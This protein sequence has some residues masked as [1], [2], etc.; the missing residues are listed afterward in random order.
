MLVGDD[1]VNIESYSTNIQKLYEQVKQDKALH[2]KHA[3]LHAKAF[4]KEAKKTEDASL[5]GVAYFYLGS[6]CFDF[7]HNNKDFQT[8]LQQAILYLQNT[9]ETGYLMQ[10]YNHLG[11]D[12]HNHGNIQLSMDYY[13]KA[14]N[15]LGSQDPTEITAMIMFNI[16]QIYIQIEEYKIALRYIKEAHR[17]IHKLPTTERAMLEGYCYCSEGNINLLLHR[18][19][20]ARRSLA[21]LDKV[22]SESAAPE[23]ISQDLFFMLFRIRM[24]NEEGDEAARDR[25]I[26]LFLQQLKRGEMDLGSI[27]EVLD[28]IQLMIEIEHYNAA[29]ETVCY[30]API[31]AESDIPNIQESFAKHRITLYSQMNDEAAYLG[32]LNDYYRYAELHK[33]SA[34][35]AY[36]IALET[37]LSLDAMKKENERLSAAANTDRLT[38]IPNRGALNDYLEEVFE[39]CYHMEESLGIE[40]L[41]IDFFKEYNDTYGHQ[42]GDEVLIKIAGILKGFTEDSRIYVGRY[43]GDEFVVVYRNMTDEE[44]MKIAEE[45]RNRVLAL[46]ISHKY[47]KTSPI[48]TVSQ[49][50]RNRVPKSG[51]KLWDFLYTADNALYQVKK[52][53]KGQI[54]LMHT[55]FISSKSLADST[56]I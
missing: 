6:A 5:I 22:I 37:R 33:S 35:K 40:F 39:D 2:D 49:G 13:M 14:L 34:N 31:L 18:Q 45:I 41:D 7:K 51:N 11:I 52:T 19:A 47:S 8:S 30:T 55:A 27:T 9:E 48:V 4:L 16:G 3:M 21:G 26:Q 56:Q 1:A 42:A 43:G 28:F 44:I 29:E 17:I 20:S 24:S 32:A 38:G 25:Q 15:L 23:E 36:A 54:M 53:Q 12:A 10:V 50:I 46:G